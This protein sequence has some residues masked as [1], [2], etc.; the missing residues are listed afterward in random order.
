[1]VKYFTPEI[2]TALEKSLAEAE[3]DL[4]NRDVSAFLRS[5]FTFHEIL[6]DASKNVWLADILKNLRVLIR[7]MAQDYRT[8]QNA[9][10]QNLQ[11]NDYFRAMSKEL[12]HVTSNKVSGNTQK[13][14]P[15]AGH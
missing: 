13:S 1:M 7:R 9:L 14:T 6:Y 5:D 12:K 8:S 2:E 10:V 11:I 15:I 4:K 3:A